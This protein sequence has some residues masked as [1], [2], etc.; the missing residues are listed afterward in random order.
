MEYKEN[1]KIK[2]RIGFVHGISEPSDP[3]VIIKMLTMMAGTVEPMKHVTQ[4][5]PHE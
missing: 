1:I 4:Y 2:K 3:I 5:F